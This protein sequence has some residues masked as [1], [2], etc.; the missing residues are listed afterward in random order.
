[1]YI[2][3]IDIGEIS[4]LQ[5][6]LDASR[7]HVKHLEESMQELKDKISLLSDSQKNDTQQI[8]NFRSNNAKLR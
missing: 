1:M 6:R 2:I 4:E 5:G 7:E 3:F 8:E